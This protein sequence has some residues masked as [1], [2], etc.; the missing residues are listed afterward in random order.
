M[1]IDRASVFAERFKG[2]PQILQAAVLGQ[3]PVPGLD[4]YTALRSLQLIKEEQRMQMAQAAQNPTQSPSLVQQAMQMPQVPP[5][6]MAQMGQMQGGAPQAPMQAPPQA[7]MQPPMQAAGGGLASFNV[8]EEDYAGGGIVAF[9]EPTEENNYSLVTEPPDGGGGDGFEVGA[10]TP[11]GMRIAASDI[12]DAE[13]GIEDVLSPNYFARQAAREFADS[14]RSSYV[15]ATEEEL[16]RRQRSVFRQMQEEA[17]PSP[18]DAIL[19][20]Y[21]GMLK[22]GGK[23]KDQALGMALLEAAG[24]AVQPGGTV[25]GLAAAASTIGRSYGAA[26][27]EQRREEMA[28]ERMR[29]ELLDSQRKER[30]GM[31]KDARL[32]VEAAERSKREAD[33]AARDASRYRAD[34]AA[35]MAA[36]LRPQ[37]EGAGPKLAEQLAAAEVAFRRDPSEENA[38]TVDALRKAMDRA[39]TSEYGAGRLGLGETGIA[40]QAET[41]V[42][43]ALEDWKTSVAAKNYRKLLRTDPAKAAELE[44]AQEQIFR[45]RFGVLSGQT[46]PAAAA[47]TAAPAAQT[48]PPPSGFTLDNR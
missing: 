34:T 4:P 32:S 46:A 15:P 33:K 5:Q 39:R 47:A 10:V 11:G 48:P 41:R 43:Q 21:E 13:A 38:Q 37:R 2:K 42:S 30:M 31:S 14:R 8:P 44:A 23:Q 29:A 7:P 35:R 20:K 3:A 17:G 1:V 45:R 12:D 40:T 22:E 6:I 36:A 28:L 25:R 16:A 26:M 24:A 9:A 27:K 18:L 19:K